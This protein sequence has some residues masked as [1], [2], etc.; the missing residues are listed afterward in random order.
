MLLHDVKT[1]LSGRQKVKDEDGDVIAEMPE[2]RHRPETG[3]VSD[4]TEQSPDPDHEHA[5]EQTESHTY[6]AFIDERAEVGTTK[7][8]C[9]RNDDISA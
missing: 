8:Q 7:C 2:P 1:L 3:R 9:R 5:L 6:L 4:F